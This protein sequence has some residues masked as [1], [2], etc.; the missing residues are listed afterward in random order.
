MVKFRKRRH[1]RGPLPFKY[2][3]LITL[4]FFAVSI[5]LGLWI[6]NK[7]LK[8]TLMYFAESQTMQIAS[9]AV[10]KAVLEREAVDI[11]KVIMKDA[12]SSLIYFDTEK[13]NEMRGETTQLILNNI[14]MAEE[15][16]LKELENISGFEIKEHPGEDEGLVYYIP[17]GKAT[18]NALLGNI[19]PQIPVRFNAIG[20]L[21]SDIKT[22]FEE[23]GINNVYIEIYIDLKVHVQII[24]PFATEVAEIK[25]RIPIAVGLLEGDVPQFYNNGG[26]GIMPSLQLPVD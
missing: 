24:I 4:M 10:N 22:E 9:L 21:E 2:V 13:I 12:E 25:Q 18:N 14:K 26:Q 3:L 7:S 5:G 11:N 23:V 17:L 16:D 6:V 15:G 19:G 8:P 20:H 1:R